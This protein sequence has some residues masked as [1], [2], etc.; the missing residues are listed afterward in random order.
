[1]EN[2]DPAVNNAIGNSDMSDDAWKAKFIEYYTLNAPAKV[3]LVTQKMMDRYRGKY[4]VLM[5]NLIKKYGPLG[6]PL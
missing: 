3:K 1:M 5:E 4:D 2:L 6:Q